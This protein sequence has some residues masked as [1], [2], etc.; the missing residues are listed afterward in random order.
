[1]S[2][3]KRASQLM[4]HPSAIVAGI[5]KCNNDPYDAQTNPE[6]FLNFGTAENTLMED[7]LSKKLSSQIEIKS[8]HIQ[9]SGMDV[10]ALRETFS[11]FAMNH[12]NIEA[13]KPENIVVQCGVS[14]I[15][16]ALSF[17]L[18]DEGDAIMIATP[19]YNGFEHD[20]TKRFK[21]E[22]VKVDL[23]PTNNFQHSIEAFEQAYNQ[24]PEPEKIK[25]VLICHPH[26][27]TGEILSQE[28]MFSLLDFIQNKKLELI[29]DEIYALS[30]HCKERHQSL[31][32]LARERKLPAHLL[33]GMAKDFAI[34]GFKVGFFYSEDNEL[35]EAMSSLC[36][37]HPVASL[38]QLAVADLLSDEQF[39]HHY[40]ELNQ[41]R[42][43]KT[44]RDLIHRNDHLNFLPAEAG[45]FI[46]L[47][48]SQWCE[49]FEDEERYHQFILD[50]LKINILKGRDLG[51]SKPGYFRVCFARPEDQIHTFSQRMQKLKRL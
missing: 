35:V 14:A 46:V 44:K 1:M 40:I 41:E 51:L 27:P 2:L 20:F 13:L 15:C 33:Y 23:S 38:T 12:L 50:E 30:T 22:F 10:P 42:L 8:E 24:Y 3:S 18:F 26:N 16:E 7:L 43:N 49:S 48:L 36:Y 17:T 21:C 4:N 32:Q 45:L 9:Y 19:Y 47:D 5:I 28:F 11:Q 37:F 39:L 34:A 25:A 6:G 31:Y 29:S